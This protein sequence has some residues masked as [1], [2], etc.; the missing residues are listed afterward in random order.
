[1][2]K[3]YIICQMYICPF[4]H[5]SGLNITPDLSYPHRACVL[6]LDKEEAIDIET[7][8][9]YDYVSRPSRIYDGPIVE[10]IKD[11]RRVAI[12][13]PLLEMVDE[14]TRHK[15]KKIIFALENG[16]EYPNGNSVLSNEEY[17]EK[18]NLKQSSDKPKIKKIGKNKK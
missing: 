12:Y 17:L 13:S 1:M 4:I 8:L 5:L 14:K 11:E 10:K 18:M 15:G 2:N 16:K 3:N 6:D 7:E 9:K